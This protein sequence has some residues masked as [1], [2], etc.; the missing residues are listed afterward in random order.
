MLFIAFTEM[1][2]ALARATQTVCVIVSTPMGLVLLYYLSGPP[3]DW[4]HSWPALLGSGVGAALG[5][6]IGMYLCVCARHFCAE[7]GARAAL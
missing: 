2:R 5:L 7:I 6:V 4:A 3:D 1:R